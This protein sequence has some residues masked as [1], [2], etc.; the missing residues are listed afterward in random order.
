MPGAQVDAVRRF[1]RAVTQRVG[2]LDDEYL[3]RGRSLGLSRLLWEVE[4]DGSEVRVLRSRLGLDSG[5]LSRQL[6]RLEADGLVT[7]DP[8]SGDGRVRR[9]RLTPA[10]VAERAVLNAASDELAESILDPLSDSQRER[11]VGAMTEIERLLLA[12][13]VQIKPTDPRDPDARYCLRS[14]FEELGRRFD[15]GFDPAQSIA[16]SDADMT[17]PNGLLLVAT[18]QDAPIGCGA[19]KVHHESG[20]AEV[21]RMWT[22]REVRRL[23]LGRRILEQL[24]GAATA[25]GMRTLRLETN[26]CLVEARQLYET[27]GFIEVAAFNDEPYAHHW[28]QRDLAGS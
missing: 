28:F 23:G 20:I 13:Q 7:T 5:Y 22:S 17:P 24:A 14:Y 12:S 15:G 9:V 2:A 19:L 18:L 6:R 21:K 27:A 26:Q 16:A 3:S 1:N 25:A 8:D 11:L 10:G 4:P